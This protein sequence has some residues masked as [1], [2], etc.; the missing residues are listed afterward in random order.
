MPILAS[1]FTSN[2]LQGTVVVSGGQANIQL[3]LSAFAFEGQKTFNVRLRKDGFTGI[4]LA[5]SN[6]I[7]IPDTNSNIISFTSN[8]STMNETSSNVILFTITTANVPSG[9]NIYYTT[10]SIVNGYF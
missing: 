5:S 9:A 3:P 7:T 1:N 8:I 10:N 2:S 6:V 4:I